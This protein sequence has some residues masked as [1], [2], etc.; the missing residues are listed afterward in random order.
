MDTS[1][2]SSSSTSAMGHYAVLLSTVGELRGELEKTVSKMQSMEEQ[3][4]AMQGNYKTLK[5]ELIE[6]RKKYNESQENYMTTVAAKFEQER[7]HEGLLE[8]VMSQLTD[9]TKEFETL[10]EKFVPQDIDYIRIK[11]QEELEIPHKQRI[12]SMEEEVEKHKEMFYKVQRDL[13]RCKADFETHSVLQQRNT[14][15][16][17]TEHEA[18]M[19][20]L[21]VY[22]AQL[23]DRNFDAEK[24]DKIRSQRVKLGELEQIVTSLRAEI[25]SVRTERDEV[26]YAAEQARLRC[27]DDMNSMRTKMVVNEADKI[28]AEKRVSLLLSEIDGKDSQIRSTKA[29]LVDATKHTDSLRLELADLQSTVDR[30]REDGQVGLDNQRSLFDSEREEQS[31]MIETLHGKIHSREEQIR[32]TQRE[33]AEAQMRIEA[34]EVD[35]RRLYSGQLNE[36]RT[37]SDNL[38]LTVADLRDRLTAQVA[39]LQRGVD[40]KA[41]EL[42]ISKSDG[43]RMRREKGMLHEKLQAMETRLVSEKSKASLLKRDLSTRLQVSEERETRLRDDLRTTQT[44]LDESNAHDEAQVKEIRK[45]QGRLAKMESEA[46]ERVRKE[47]D[48]AK[49]TNENIERICLLKLEEGKRQSKELIAKERRKAEQYREK[50]LESHARN[51]ALL[52]RFAPDFDAT[53]SMR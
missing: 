43:A 39:Q 45:L 6:T 22:V 38:Q 7:Q 41:S 30:I 21:Q 2:T 4:K 9:K 27:E 19:N 48:S 1:N 42:E 40:S 51:K 25:A 24:D 44:A 28:A 17:V 11:V 34:V 32:R 35:T 14:S 46:D 50:A 37:R 16:L 31:A 12:L 10:R 33:L 5:D 8:R 18:S 3:N 52:S 15:A 47:K 36:S 13:E 23:K 26:L 20:E 49:E 53:T 29:L